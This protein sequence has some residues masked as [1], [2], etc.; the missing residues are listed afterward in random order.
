MTLLSKISDSAS[1]ILLISHLNA[2]PDAI[3]SSIALA[4][5]FKSKK[6]KA[7]VGCSQGV[8]S[9][10]RNLVKKLNYKIHMSPK[11]DD[12]DT[13]VILDTTSFA[14]LE[15]LDVKGFSGKIY[16]IDHHA[17]NSE[18]KDICDECLNMEDAVATSEIIYN[19]LKKEKFAVTKKMALSLL[20]GII[21]DTGHLQFAKPE[22][23]K[24]VSDLVEISGM[25]YSDI[26]NMI[27]VQTEPS[28]KIAQLKSASRLE[29]RKID[30]WIIVLSHVGS[31]EAS[32]ARA[33]IKIGA[34]VSFVCSKHQR[35]VRICARASN[36]FV[37]DTGINF[38]NDVMPSI[39]KKINGS[40]GGH[41]AAASVNGTFDGSEIELLEVCMNLLTE[42]LT[43]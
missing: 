3:G 21:T 24:A 19:L 17:S 39:A 38:G 1:D 27:T 2:D 33:L 8:N 35:K 10:A 43:A 36:K 12:Y 11:L 5:Y 37:K 14:Q 26:L 30:D 28:R 13:L 18:F 32:S 4:E 7:I 15:P 40:G 29:L 42:K 22:T 31:F 16:V 34:D 23:F 20:A 41:I 6:K 9:L 25:D